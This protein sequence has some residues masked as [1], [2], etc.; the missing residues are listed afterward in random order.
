M[1]NC[2]VYIRLG[3]NKLCDII[4]VEG[5]QG[6]VIHLKAKVQIRIVCAP[7]IALISLPI[8][9]NMC[10]GCSKEPSH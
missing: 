7:K 2:S 5:C 1:L 9:L 6:L 4:E 8:N 10:F 3:N